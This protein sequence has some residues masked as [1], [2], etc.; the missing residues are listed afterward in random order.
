MF[1][2]AIPI[3]I[4]SLM[5]CQVLNSQT[6]VSQIKPICDI[7]T[8]FHY[9]ISDSSKTNGFSLNRAYL[10]I[11]YEPEGYWSSVIMI[12]VGN[13][14]DLA[15]G[16]VPKRYAYLREAAII[17]KKD[18][19]TF[20]FGMVNTRYE[21][22]QQGFWGKRYLG[23]E[24]QAIYGYGS[25]ADLGVVVDYQLNNVFKFDIS[26]IN[27]KGYTNIQP[28]NS[29][30]TAAGLTITTPNRISIRL[31]GDIMKPFGVWQS[32]MIGFAGF[33]TSHLSFGAEAS[34][35][36]NLD[37]THGHDVWGLS[38]TGS[39][40][41]NENSEIFARYDY[42]ASLKTDENDLQWDSEKDG[43]YLIAGIQHKF[44]DKIKM[45]LNYRRMNPYEP[46]I[47]SS[48]AVYLNAAFKF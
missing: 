17:Y 23:P 33:K 48:N 31:Y 39:Y 16:S 40:Y 35:K 22:F 9:Y 21:D 7:F 11:D 42:M 37:L 34:Y 15:P 41:L 47:K 8:D 2:R 3:F 12:N 25:V 28:D 4:L 44:N 10:G 24:F 5:I 43:S 32:T 36:T 46:A 20:N 27:G 38:G 19:L 29:I 18:R 13:P 45:A 14:E 1:K 30:K 6:L 26:V